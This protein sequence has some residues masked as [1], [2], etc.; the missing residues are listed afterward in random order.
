MDVNKQRL[1]IEY[2]ISSPDTYARCAGIIKTDYFDPEVKNSVAF[3]TKY[4]EKYNTTPDLEQIKAETGLVFKKRD[5]EFDV[6]KLDYCANEIETFCKQRA[7]EKAI[8]D[9]VPLIEEGKYGKINDLIEEALMVS[10][11]KDLGVCYFDDVEER[12]TRML[13]N[14]PTHSTGWKEVDD[15]LFGGI[16]RKELLL[17]A[18]NS[19]GGKSITLSNLGYNF[20]EMGK[21]V[22]YISLEL[23]KDIVAQRYDTM[24]TGIGRKDWQ[25]HTKEI[26]TTVTSKKES[27]GRMDIVHLPAGTTAIGIRAYLK[28]YMLRFKITP[29]LLIVDYLDEMGSNEG[30]SSENIFEKDKACASQLRQIG[31]DFEMF[32]ATASQLNRSAVGAT[33]HD[34]S[35]IAG[36]ISKINIADV[37]WK[38]IQ[39]DVQKL[40]GEITFIF[41]KSINSD[42]N[43]RVIE[44]KWDGRRLRILD[45]DDIGDESLDFRPKKKSLLDETPTGNKLMEL[46]NNT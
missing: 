25:K 29:D 39:T 15:A 32:T 12:L 33:H 8:L 1:M 41:Q 10:L 45:R 44:L 6:D 38:I 34:H 20:S 3:I 21:V 23:D 19:G 46:L 42:G 43:G 24:F 35:Q 18:A 4:Y 5:T 37:Y 31:V 9:S 2:L 7:M 13:E 17:V 27:H 11:K 40:N 28:E 26:I 36:G 30:I 14:P 22:L 16:S